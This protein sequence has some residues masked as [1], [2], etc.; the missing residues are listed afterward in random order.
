[1]ATR[2]G[3]RPRSPLLSILDFL[4][5]YWFLFPIVGGFIWT[6]A[7]LPTEGK[8]QGKRIEK[9]ESRQ[10]TIEQYIEVSEEQKKLIK[11]APPGWKW[12]E[13]TE[14]YLEWKDDPRIK[15]KK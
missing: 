13:V 14:T 6:L 8:A 10:E 4:K 1:M 2:Q 3:K 9:V 12:D 7:T 11:A 5:S 15:R